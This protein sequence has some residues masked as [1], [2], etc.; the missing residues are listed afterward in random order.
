M[1]DVIL[2]L[3]YDLDHDTIYGNA[4]DTINGDGGD[5][6]ITGGSGNDVITGGSGHDIIV[7][8]QPDDIVHVASSG[9]SSNYKL[10]D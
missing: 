5:D 1:A 2:V 4:N 8:T 3:F 6:V 7:S 9:A 10:R